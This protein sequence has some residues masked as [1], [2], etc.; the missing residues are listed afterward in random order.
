ME[1]TSQMTEELTEQHIIIVIKRDAIKLSRQEKIE[2]LIKIME[3]VPD[4]KIREKGSGTQVDLQDVPLGT[5]YTLYEYVKSCIA[6]K[7]NMV[8][9]LIQSVTIEN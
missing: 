6:Q 3:T 9:K 5:L 1:Y 7:N 8:E 4:E 2:I